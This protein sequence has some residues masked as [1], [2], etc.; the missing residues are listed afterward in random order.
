MNVAFE[1][2]DAHSFPL[3]PCGGGLGRGVTGDAL[4]LNLAPSRPASP[5]DLPRKGGG[6]ESRKSRAS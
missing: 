2:R 5:A 4:I 1:F 6:E 3:P